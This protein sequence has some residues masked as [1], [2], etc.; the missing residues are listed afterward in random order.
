[1]CCA[2]IF[3][4]WISVMIIGAVNHIIDYFKPAENLY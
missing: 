1:M 4:V 2:Y 3:V